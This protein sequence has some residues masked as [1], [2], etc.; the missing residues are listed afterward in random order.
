M[1]LKEQVIEQLSALPD[2]FSI[3]EAIDKLIFLDKLQTR[4]NEID[5]KEEISSEELDTEIE[6]W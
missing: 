5:L 4:L 6:K 2:E 3:E 1:L